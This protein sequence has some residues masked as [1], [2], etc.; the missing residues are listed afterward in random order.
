MR[1]RLRDDG[2]HA[3]IEAAAAVLGRRIG[4]DRDD[5]RRLL[6]GRT[7][8]RAQLLRRSVAIHHRHLAIHQDSVERAGRN[9]SERLCTVLDSGHVTADVLQHLGEHF[10]IHRVVFGEKHGRCKR[11]RNAR[12]RRSLA[13][14]GT[15]MSLFGRTLQHDRKRKHRAAVGLARERDPP[16]HQ[17]HEPAHDRKSETRTAEASC[18]ARLRL[19][20][21]LEDSFAGFRRHADACIRN[22]K[23]Q[24]RLFALGMGQRAR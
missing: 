24:L 8:E 2:V 18:R 9:G 7:F 16:A 14:P 20:E 23:S 22:G 21:W 19:R 6:A 4:G 17:R 1:D 3:G 10:P 13:K 5:E 12:A 11:E 15:L